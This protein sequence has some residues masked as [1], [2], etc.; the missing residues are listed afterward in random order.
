MSAVHYFSKLE[1]LKNIWR[2]CISKCKNLLKG[3]EPGLSFYHISANGY[4]F[5]FVGE[6]EKRPPEPKPNNCNIADVM[7]MCSMLFVCRN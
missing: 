6:I 7:F 1:V 4:G 3:T 2:Y 5:A